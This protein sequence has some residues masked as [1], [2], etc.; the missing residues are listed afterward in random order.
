MSNNMLVLKTE[1]SKKQLGRFV[2]LMLF[3]LAPSVSHAAEGP[4]SVFVKEVCGGRLSAIILSAFKGEVRNS[5]KYQLVPTL[6]D[7]GRMN[8]VLEIEMSCTDR[9]SVVAI[10]T[11]YGAAKCFG[12]NNCHATI[13]GSS[14]SASLC[15]SNALAECGRALF[16]VFDGYMSHP[17][18]ARLKLQ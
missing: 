2:L 5:Q 7:N 13:D 9:D 12:P 14:L 1:W 11:V 6:D 4:R 17:N 16:K 3:V 10:A 8:V 18:P 15:D